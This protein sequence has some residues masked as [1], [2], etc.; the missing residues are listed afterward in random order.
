M[1]RRPHV[2]QIRIT[3]KCRRPTKMAKWR[4]GPVAHRAGKQQC[5]QPEQ[6]SS[7][8][9]M[10]PSGTVQASRYQTWKASAG[11]RRIAMRSSFGSWII[12]AANEGS[13]IQSPAKHRTA[14]SLSAGSRAGVNRLAGLGA[15]ARGDGEARRREAGDNAHGHECCRSS[16]CPSWSMSGA[17]SARIEA[18]TT[19]NRPNRPGGNHSVAGQ[20]RERPASERVVTPA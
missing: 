4:D 10:K 8:C 3:S 6:S 7:R 12:A 14:A 2:H 9:L 19:I 1:T 5:R 11:C 17:P 15:G 20:L 13:A 18:V 16:T